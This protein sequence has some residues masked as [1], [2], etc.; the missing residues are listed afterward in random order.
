MF[1]WTQLLLSC[2]RLRHEDGRVSVRVPQGGVRAEDGYGLQRC[3]L[4]VVEPPPGCRRRNERAFAWVIPLAT[5]RVDVRAVAVDRR[6]LA[7]HSSAPLD[8]DD[9]ERAAG[10]EARFV[11]H[12]R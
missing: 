8:L 4:P 7:H 12:A 2:R 1:S 6:S 5:T 9:G 11:A 10:H 3:P